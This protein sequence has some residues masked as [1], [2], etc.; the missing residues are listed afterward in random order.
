[1]GVPPEAPLGLALTSLSASIEVDYQIV[2]A[3]LNDP[4]D[5]EQFSGQVA[6]WLARS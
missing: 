1:M 6:E 3:R 4:T 5:L 2:L